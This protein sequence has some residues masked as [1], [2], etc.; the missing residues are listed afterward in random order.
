MSKKYTEMQIKAIIKAT[1]EFLSSGVS[2]VREIAEYRNKLS[3]REGISLS[4]KDVNLLY[5]L[6]KN[7]TWIYDYFGSDFW[8]LARE[9]V[10]ENWTEETFIDR[11]FSHIHD[12]TLDEE[13][14]RDLQDLYEYTRGTRT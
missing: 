12:R 10:K 14:R 8:D 6:R 1:N 9:S 5:Q 4:I 11:V 13:L 2:T 7:Y 3:Q